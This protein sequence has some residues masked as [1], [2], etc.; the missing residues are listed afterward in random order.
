MAPTHPKGLG[1]YLHALP[2]AILHRSDTGLMPGALG[3]SYECCYFE[4]TINSV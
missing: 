2:D 4:A 1:Y 3:S